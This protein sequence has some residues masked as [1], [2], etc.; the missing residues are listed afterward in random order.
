MEAAQ[1]VADARAEDA[2]YD[3]AADNAIWQAAYNAAE[4]P[5]HAIAHHEATEAVRAARAATKA[6]IV[7]DVMELFS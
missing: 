5:Y 7:A 6:Q 2:R 3:L 4:T 1:I